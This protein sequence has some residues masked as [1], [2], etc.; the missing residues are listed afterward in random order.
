MQYCAH[1]I[2]VDAPSSQGDFNV[3]IEYKLSLHKQISNLK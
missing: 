1:G 3:T 2:S